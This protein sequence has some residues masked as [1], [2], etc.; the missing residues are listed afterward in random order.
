MNYKAYWIHRTGEIFPVQTTHIAE[1]I[2]APQHFNY[3]RERIDAEY[4][5]FQ[6]P[7]GHEGKARQLIMA[8]LIQN[9]GWIRIRYTPRNDSWVVEVNTLSEVVKKLLVR[10]FSDPE[11]VRNSPHSTIRVTELSSIEGGILHHNTTIRDLCLKQL[12]GK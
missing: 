10:F 9:H 4:S 8:N 1:V 11:I 2:N 3:S 5:F 7:I 12:G 6:E